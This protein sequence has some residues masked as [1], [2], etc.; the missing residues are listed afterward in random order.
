VHGYDFSGVEPE[1]NIMY[2]RLMK[3][4]APNLIT[5]TYSKF[6]KP[7]AVQKLKD[8]NPNL[9]DQI[10]EKI[11]Q[12]TSERLKYIKDFKKIKNRRRSLRRIT[13]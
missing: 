1:Q 13:P 5:W 3:R 6:L 7:E 8:Q 12:E 2:D 10:N 4:F 9:I 11:H